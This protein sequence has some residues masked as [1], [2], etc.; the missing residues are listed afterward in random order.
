M[1]TPAS[2]DPHAELADPPSVADLE[3]YVS[4]ALT[5][6]ARAALEQRLASD[7][8]LAGE[9]AEVRAHAA[10]A[11]RMRDR[12]ADDAG[13]EPFGPPRLEDYADLRE[14][15]RGGQGVVYAA[16]QLSTGREVALKVMPRGTLHTRRQEQRF[17]REID[18]ASSLA[19]PHVVPVFDRGVTEDGRQYFVMELIDGLAV[20]RH[21][22][23]ERL[24]VPGRLELFDRICAAVAYA[25]RRG[26]IHRDLKPENL[27]V[28]GSG[29]PRVLDFGLAKLHTDD[30]ERHSLVTQA[31][32]FVGT[33]AFASPEQVRGDPADVDVRT[34]VYALGVVLYRL[35]TGEHPYPVGG[36]IGDAIEHI[37]ST[38]PPRPSKRA[39]GLD[40]DLDALCLTCLTKSPDDRYPSVDALRA[41]LRN[42]RDDLP[43][44]ARSDRRG[45]VLRR[46][47]HRYRWPLA[48]VAVAFVALVIT[49]LVSLDALAEAN[50]E[51]SRAV[52]LGDF[53]VETLVSAEPGLHPRDVTVSQLVQRAALELD[54][55]FVGQPAS[56]AAVRDAIGQVH[57]ASG[58]FEPAEAQYLAAL[59]LLSGSH[60]DGEQQVL[61]TRLHLAQMLFESG[62]WDEAE[63]LVAELDPHLAARDAADALTRARLQLMGSLRVAQGRA[64]E[65]V[66]LMEDWLGAL[67]A[68][69]GEGPTPM[70][71]GTYADALRESGEL[72]EALAVHEQALAQRTAVHGPGHVFV[73]RARHNRALLLDELGRQ[74]EALDEL[75][76]VAAAL[77]AEL[78]DAHPTTKM[79]RVNLANALHKAGKD[80]EALPLYVE[81]VETCRVQYGDRHRVTLDALHGLGTVLRGQGDLATAETLLRMALEGRVEVQGNGHENTLRTRVELA[82]CIGRAGALQEAEA[83]LRE[84][85]EHGHSSL[86]S[87]SRDTLDA[88][89]SLAVLLLDTERT[90]AAEQL[91]ADMIS[92]ADE[93]LG[94]GDWRPSRYRMQRGLA[95]ARLGRGAEAVPL[96]E[97]AHAGFVAT[98]GFDEGYAVATRDLLVQVHTALGDEDAAAGWREAG[99]GVGP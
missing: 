28:D 18:L 88:E 83:I 89:Y 41:D 95:L 75:R 10:L 85:V 25:H 17:E 7:E 45:Y 98:R 29:E 46:T 27:L 72:D 1:K 99:E 26:I 21:V 87:G 30:G 36:A 68:A 24:D 12:L 22:E 73:N 20:D 91:F 70:L 61:L 93:G 76:S 34:D 42:W 78:G 16:R 8:A 11:A 80:D 74:D 53:L 54:G 38:D 47:L 81:L 84:A 97:A 49:T 5:D 3:R 71:L 60:D 77:H 44:Q 15:Q 92:R 19:H 67:D 52:G 82:L 56:E 86:G 9:L 39:A 32:E 57:Q 63:A 51:A 40:A 48:G 62:R 65:A 55:R 4:G 43:L 13:D 2:D 66:R 23:H 6:A 58:E 33:L 94:P 37:T 14:L 50:Q 35:L 69:G 64:P 90:V 79:A 96:L 59:A 31:G